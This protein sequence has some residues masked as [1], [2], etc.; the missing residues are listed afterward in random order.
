MCSRN[1]FICTFNY[2]MSVN[3]EDYW[4]N[5]SL[6]LLST[7]Q[8]IVFVL[9]SCFTLTCKRNFKSNLSKRERKPL[10]FPQEN[11]YVLL[12]DSILDWKMWFH[13]VILLGNFIFSPI[14]KSKWINVWLLFQATQSCKQVQFKQL[15]NWMFILFKAYF[16]LLRIL[17]LNIL[18]WSI[19]SRTVV[20]A[21]TL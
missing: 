4:C 9:C 11:W 3:T 17:S 20:G 12:S 16:C 10:R 5:V 6:F 8:L 19:C 7:K 13:W 15:E 21:V 2:F 14:Q 1:A 18:F